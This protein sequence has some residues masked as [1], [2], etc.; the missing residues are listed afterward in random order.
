LRSLV[1]VGDVLGPNPKHPALLFCPASERII[2]AEVEQ[3]F[4]RDVAVGQKAR[5]EDDANEGS[6]W[7]GTVTQ[8][9]D[10]YSQRRSPLLEPLQ[11]NEVII[12]PEKG[13][14][15]L[16]IG[17]RVRVRLDGTN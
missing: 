1:S 3:E 16:R 6:K 15:P 10:W 5:I 7:N 4:A 2:R 17:Q 14:D 9:S 8:V 12:R 11:F 13:K